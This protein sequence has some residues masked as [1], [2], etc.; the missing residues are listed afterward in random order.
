MHL[1][2]EQAEIEL[3]RI[4]NQTCFAGNHWSLERVGKR[5]AFTL[6]GHELGT[7]RERSLRDLV[8]LVRYELTELG[9]GVA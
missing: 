7:W 5:W 3:S 6:H 1:T 9:V 2:Y 4:V 8:R